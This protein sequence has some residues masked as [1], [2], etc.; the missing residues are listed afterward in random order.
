MH[1]R[2]EPNRPQL[3]I[4]KHDRGLELLFISQY[5][6]EFPSNPPK[7]EAEHHP[8]SYFYAPDSS[9]SRSAGC[10]SAI[11]CLTRTPETKDRK[12]LFGKE[13]RP[14]RQVER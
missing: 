3:A 2:R 12:V 13:H 6:R 14:L 11:T 7:F 4:Y 1:G 10:C 9:I 5:V 8:T